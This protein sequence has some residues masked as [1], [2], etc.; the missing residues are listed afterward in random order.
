MVGAIF[1]LF[2][3]GFC[4]NL[5]F[6]YF[7][8]NAIKKEW[9]WVL[10]GLFLL[11]IASENGF[12]GDKSDER[13]R[14]ETEEQSVENEQEKDD[15]VEPPSEEV[16]ETTDKEETN[17]VI[18]ETDNTDQATVDGS[19]DEDAE[20]PSLEDA[21]EHL[22]EDQTTSRKIEVPNDKVC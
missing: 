4:L 5:D 3:N 8:E 19:K 18:P 1:F 7:V 9:G 13:A 6:F 17:A 21:E 15:N 14:E 16:L 22:S 2:N 20:K 11:V 12:K 10:M